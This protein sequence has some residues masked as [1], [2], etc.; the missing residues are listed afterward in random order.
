[1]TNAQKITLR[2][3]QVRER[4]RAIATIEGD[5][6]TDEVRAESGN[7]ETEYADL[8]TRHRA[9]LIAEGDEAAEKRGEFG[10]GDGETAER[11]RLLE[12]VSIRDYLGPAGAGGEIRG[13]AAEL[14]APRW[15]ACA[16]ALAT[17]LVPAIPATSGGWTSCKASY[18]VWSD[19]LPFICGSARSRRRTPQAAAQPSDS[20]SACS[21]TV[22]V[23]C[24]CW[25]GG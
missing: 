17:C 3:S 16:P 2:I 13:A 22:I 20:T 21:S 24:S 6:F 25:S 18:T 11:R 10:G 14:A 8:A 15:S 12:A 5:A 19:R 9:A 4:L 23:A 7:L 1:M